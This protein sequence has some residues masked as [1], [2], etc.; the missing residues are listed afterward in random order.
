MYMIRTSKHILKFANK[1]KLNILDKIY[2]DCKKQ[3]GVY[4]D[5]I[6]SGKLELKKL[7][8]SKLLSSEFIKR[9]TWKQICYG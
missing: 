8:S 6:I 1:E 5:E 2:S 9:S 3:I 7:M 4:I